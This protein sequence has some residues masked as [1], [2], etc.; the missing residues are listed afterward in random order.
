MVECHLSLNIWPRPLNH[1]INGGRKILPQKCMIV[2]FGAAMA[3]SLHNLLS[4]PW[5]QFKNIAYNLSA[6]LEYSD[7]GQK[8]GE[9]P[10]KLD[11][12][13]V[14]TVF[15]GTTSNTKKEESRA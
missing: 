14:S 1:V 7:Y 5:L 6:P 15:A 9:I 11:K 2:A 8:V 4:V 3:A 13:Q 12:L 10:K